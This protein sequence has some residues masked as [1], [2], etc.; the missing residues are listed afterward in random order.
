MENSNRTETPVVPKLRSV[1]SPN[2]TPHSSP[3]TQSSSQLLQPTSTTFYPKDSPSHIF[4][5]SSSSSSSTTNTTTSSSS[6]FDPT[7]NNLISSS[8][9]SQLR[10]GGLPNSSNPIDVLSGRKTPF[11]MPT[12]H[13]TPSSSSRGDRSSL[14]TGEGRGGEGMSEYWSSPQSREWSSPATSFHQ[15]SSTDNDGS[16]DQEKGGNL[17]ESSSNYQVS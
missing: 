8:T 7:T 9:S 13:T 4:F 17:Q 2:L 16:P 12:S 1:S 14:S 11:Y 6:T 5:T 15:S 10:T 3:S